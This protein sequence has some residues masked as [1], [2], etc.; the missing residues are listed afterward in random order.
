MKNLCILL[1]H[2][3]FGEQVNVLIM[4]YYAIS[5]YFPSNSY[6]IIMI[7]VI[8][9]L[10]IGGNTSEYPQIGEYFKVL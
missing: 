1:K 10:F 5:M 2:K 7:I 3:W 9:Y 4:Q 8:Y 6:Y